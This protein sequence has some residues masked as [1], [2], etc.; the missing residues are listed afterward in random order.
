MIKRLKYDIILVYNDITNNLKY[1]IIQESNASNLVWNKF[2][3][4]QKTHNLK[5]P[6][7]RKFILLSNY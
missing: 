3:C 4:T 2:K 1:N 5:L 7:K 6:I